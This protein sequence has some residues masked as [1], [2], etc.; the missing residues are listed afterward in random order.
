MG[1]MRVLIVSDIQGN[2][3]A[4]SSLVEKGPAQV[5]G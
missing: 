5:I 3:D 4:L 1:S 2:Y